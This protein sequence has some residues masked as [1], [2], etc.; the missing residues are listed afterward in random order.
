MKAEDDASYVA[1]RGMCGVTPRAG[2]LPC[3]KPKGR[4]PIHAEGDKQC[5]SAL[6]DEPDARCRHYRRGSSAFCD[7]HQDRPNF[8]LALKGFF[9][10]HAGKL[11]TEDALRAWDRSRFPGA[12]RELT[13]YDFPRYITRAAQNCGFAVDSQTGRV[14][15]PP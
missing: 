4:C 10:E 13:V 8:C 14:G 6:D 1:D 3:S 7:F 9:A 12:D 2:G 11:V 5:Q 15:P